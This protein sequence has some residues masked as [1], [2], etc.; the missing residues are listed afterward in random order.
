[1]YLHLGCGCVILPGFINLDIRDGN[2]IDKTSLVYPIDYDNDTFDLIY[3]SHVLEHFPRK[4][5]T[6]V[7]QEWARILKKG[8]ILRLSV[9]DIQALINIYKQTKDLD[10]I[11][12]P[13]YGRQDYRYNYHY[14]VFDYIIIK[15]LMEKSGLEAIHYWDF[16]RT[17]H[18]NYWDY[19][20]AE[21][22]GTLISLNV[23]GR[24]RL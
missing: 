15:K 7:L 12:G 4:Q 9:P 17:I 2:G 11:I 14:T 23:E 19:S 24:K 3:A 13:L 5:T 22:K 10:Q 21:T 18:A 6:N 8:G 16:R 1:M 20:Q